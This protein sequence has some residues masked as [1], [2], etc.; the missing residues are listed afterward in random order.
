MII[1]NVKVT[2][3]DVFNLNRAVQ[4]L[5][6]S[7]QKTTGRVTLSLSDTAKECGKIL[8]KYQP[9][10]EKID[11]KYLFR[12]EEGQ[13]EYE[14]LT[15]EQKKKGIQPK[16]KLKEGKTHDEMNKELKN[17]FKKEVVLKVRTM[18]PDDF[19]VLEFNQQMNPLISLVCDIMV[20]DGKSKLVAVQ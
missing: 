6:I 1:E 11:K 18:T 12:N 19:G 16:V 15:E 5:V 9:E 20:K 13:V 4:D 8:K 10:K 17:F 7:S 2:L 14:T 3:G